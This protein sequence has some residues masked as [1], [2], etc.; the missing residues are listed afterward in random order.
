MEIES[1]KILD[2][3]SNKIEALPADISKL[4]NLKTLL[5]T[6][7]PLKSLPDSIKDMK[8]LESIV[9]SAEQKELK[10]FIILH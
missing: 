1:L 6:G 7:N 9:L 5:L 3:K 8:K 2:L 4:K 10:I